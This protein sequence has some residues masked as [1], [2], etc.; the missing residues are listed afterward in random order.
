LGVTLETARHW[1]S[2]HDENAPEPAPVVKEVVYIPPDKGVSMPLHLD[3]SDEP[4]TIAVLNDTHNP[5]QDDRALGLAERLLQVVQPD[6]LV[7]AGDM[8]DFYQISDFDK[9]PNR[10]GKMQ[11]DIN[12]TIKMF[13]RHK[14]IMPK[15]KQIFLV[16]NHE[17]RLRRFLW[18]RAPA[19]S[20]LDCLT[21]EELYH[22]DKFDM[23]LVPYE[24]GILVNDVFLII[25]GDIIAPHSSY[26]AKR[27]YEK[28][29]GCGMAG[30]THRGGSFY[31]RD[32]FGVYGW[33]ENHCM[34]SLDPDWIKNPNWQHGFSLVHF[35]GSHFWVEQIPIVDYAL[36]YGGKIYK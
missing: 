10:M 26:T 15:T 34:C 1:R 19:M 16:G 3:V 31:K 23:P 8:S 35:M 4:K 6:Y 17:D 11:E 22:L 28:H 33:W 21:L 12:S 9:N 36:I 2:D 25:H 7:Y 18:S 27:M 20:S 14:D 5:Y 32:R 13:A 29:G 24:Q 30:H